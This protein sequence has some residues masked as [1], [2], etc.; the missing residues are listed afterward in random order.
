ME[1][2]QLRVR[3]PARE[4]ILAARKPGPTS[5]HNVI[6]ALQKEQSPANEHRNYIIEQ[7]NQAE[8]KK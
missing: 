1:A 6:A 2:A 5:V 7:Q 8:T 4:V 3:L